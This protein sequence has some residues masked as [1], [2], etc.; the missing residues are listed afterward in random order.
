MEYKDVP[1]GFTKRM[2]IQLKA[3]TETN[4]IAAATTV[5]IEDLDIQERDWVAEEDTYLVGVEIQHFPDRAQWEALGFIS[6]I[7]NNRSI[8]LVRC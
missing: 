5:D 7:D 3:A 1:K 8:Y 2:V 4:T 6:G